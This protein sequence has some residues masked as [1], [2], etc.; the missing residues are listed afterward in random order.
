MRPKEG[1]IYEWVMIEG[2]P[3]Y[4]STLAEGVLGWAAPDL[5]GCFGQTTTDAGYDFDNIGKH[6]KKW[7]DVHDIVPLPY[8][9]H[10]KETKDA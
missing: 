1:F 3:V 7:L 10:M 9:A 4:L 6:I 8:T 5:P 2:Y